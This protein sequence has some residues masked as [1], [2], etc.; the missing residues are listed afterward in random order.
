MK[1]LWP[2]LAILTCISAGWMM[3][4]DS[5]NAE[6]A[7][8]TKE[9]PK[10]AMAVEVTHLSKRDLIESVDLVG[11]L[12]ASADIQIYTRGEG[13]LVGLPFDVQDKVKEGDVVA[14]LDES[15]Q[16]ELVASTSAALKVTRAKLKAQQTK[17]DQSLNNYRRQQELDKSGVATSQQLE[18]AKAQFEISQAELELQQAE[19]DQAIANHNSS[20][21]NLKQ[22]RVLSPVTGFVAQ[23]FT[24]VGDLVSSEKEIMRI[25]SIDKVKTVVNIVE[26]DYEKVRMGQT[27]EIRTD[28]FP[29][30]VF[31]GTVVRKSPVVDP[32]TRMAEVHIEIPN[33]DLA[34]KPGMHGRVR[35]RTNVI[36]R[37]DVLP[38]ASLLQHKDKTS[39]YVV[40]GEPAVT[41]LREVETGAS[42]GEYIEIVSGV[43]VEDRIVA[44]G[45]QMVDDGDEVAVLDHVDRDQKLAVPDPE[46][47]APQSK[48]G[49]VIPLSEKVT[50][51]A[52]E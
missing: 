39:L 51:S 18:A 6:P 4:R 14:V 11:S 17:L 22:M 42:D 25:V 43:G 29:G 37:A 21:M 23:R 31:K 24:H 5:M 7:L 12:E 41:S 40:E 34:L 48:L 50:A 32:T 9:K 15:E 49:A 27:A 46:V 2:P 36:P 20:E 10:T 19:V 8:E 1:F 16:R 38:I 33:S 45:S 3:Y 44:L 47:V 52:A 35:I 28:T 30:T 26:K 13:Y